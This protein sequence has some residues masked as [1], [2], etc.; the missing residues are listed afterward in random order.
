M[1]A[2]VAIVQGAGY[3]KPDHSHFRSTEIW[4]TA[5]PDALRAHRLARPL[6]RRGRPSEDE[7]VQRGRR[8]AGTARSADRA[9]TSTC[10]R[11]PAAA[12]L[13]PRERPQGRRTQRLRSPRSSRDDR[14]P[15]RSPYLATRRRDRRSRAARLG[16]VAET[17]RR[18]QDRRFV[19]GDRIG[20]SLALAAQIVG[21]QTRHARHLRAARFFRH[22]RGPEGDAGPLA[23]ANSPTRLKA[24]YDD[25]AAHGNDKRTL[26]MTFSEFGRRVAENASRG[27]DH[28]EAAPMF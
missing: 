18:L 20:R 8:R 19:S 9:R 22:A 25:L 3:P 2:H 27:T 7:P 17:G 15:F 23:R 24:F 13:R 26:T 4:Q 1:R 5:E 10:R 21:S 28:G 12:G 6:P 11:S 14:V 16:R